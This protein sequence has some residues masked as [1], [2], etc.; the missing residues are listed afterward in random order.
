MVIAFLIFVLLLAIW[1]TRLRTTDGEEYVSKEQCNC[2]KG[3]FI[4]LILFSHS[5]SYIEDCGYVYHGVDSI[6]PAY[7]K[8]MRQLVVVMFLFYSGYGVAVSINKKKDSY[9]NAMPLNRL[10]PTLLNYDI[11]VLV[12]I[13]LNLLLSIDM[14][15]RQIVLSF[16]AWE[17]I[18]KDTWYI[19]CI[20]VCYLSTYCLCK[21]H[22][23]E[24][25]WGLLIVLTP[26]MLALSFIK[27]H[28]W[29]D[30]MLSY[31]AGFLY[32]NYKDKINLAVKSIWRYVVALLLLLAMYVVFRYAT[33]KMQG[34]AYNLASICFAFMV[35]LVSM[36]LEIGN[37]KMLKWLGQNIF[38][39]FIYQ[40]IPMMVMKN[41]LDD[42]VI[43]RYPLA[44]IFITLGVTCVIA[45]F[46][47]YWKIGKLSKV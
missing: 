24:K 46:Y 41:K 42:G 20:L 9:V 15:A 17:D 3:I 34:L 36:K 11:A 19:F 23:S 38:P 32:A 5:L 28:Y 37:N 4:L 6:V 21:M 10:L 33:P 8:M 44:F 12:F 43:C 30:T 13:V 39:L 40:R 27:E 45:S 26:I 1:N 18:V 22:K 31:P 2:I 16:L 35:L 25:G 7:K 47:H 29:Y 14:S